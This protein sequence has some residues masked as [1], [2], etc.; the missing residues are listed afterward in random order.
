MN[1]ELTTLLSLELLTCDLYYNVHYSKN[2]LHFYRNSACKYTKNI[3]FP[4][5]NPL[6]FQLFSV[7]HI[8]RATK[9]ANLRH[10]NSRKIVIYSSHSSQAALIAAFLDGIMAHIVCCSSPEQAIATCQHEQPEIVIVLDIA[11]FIDGSDL[12]SFIRAV[13]TSRPTI[14]VIAWHQSEQIVL[15][16]LECGVDQYMTFP[17]CMSRLRLKAEAQLGNASQR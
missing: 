17:I 11:P 1:I 15:S 14:Y 8:F 9:G 4:S 16:L 6:F 12:L 2:K 13:A 7:W 5:T 3:L 10:M